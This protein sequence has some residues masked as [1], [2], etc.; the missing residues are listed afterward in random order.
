[1]EK[2]KILQIVLTETRLPTVDGDYLFVSEY[3]AVLSFFSSDMD[4]KNL[5][6]TFSAWL[7][8]VE[9]YVFTDIVGILDFISP[10]ALPYSKHH[11][12]YWKLSIDVDKTKKLIEQAIVEGKEE[13]VIVSDFSNTIKAMYQVDKSRPLEA[14]IVDYNHFSDDGDSIADEFDYLLLVNNIKDELVVI[15]HPKRI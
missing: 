13:L 3:G 7:E 10:P 4:E 6:A 11:I 12:D 2:T 14:S 9:A 15:L 8:P 1:M 5:K